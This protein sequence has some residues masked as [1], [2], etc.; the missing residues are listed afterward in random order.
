MPRASTRS[1]RASLSGRTSGSD[2][3]VRAELVGR[4]L[5]LSPPPD[6]LDEAERL[7]REWCIRHLAAPFVHPLVQLR[8][9]GHHLRNRNGLEWRQ[10]LL[11]L[12]VE[13]LRFRA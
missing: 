2:S 4:N 3:A 5:R 6:L 1:A 13:R 10:K 11:P 12:V 9:A 7:G 8:R